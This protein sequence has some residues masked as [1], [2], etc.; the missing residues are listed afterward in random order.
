MSDGGVRLHPTGTSAMKSRLEQ[1]GAFTF[2]AMVLI[3]LAAIVYYL[4]H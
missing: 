1:R 3:V 4:A 2:A